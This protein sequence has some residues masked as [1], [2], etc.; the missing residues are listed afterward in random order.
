M[1]R[2]SLQIRSQSVRRFPKTARLLVFLFALF[3]SF[4]DTLS[5]APT[6]LGD[7]DGDGLVN[8]Y[9]LTRLRAHIRGTKTLSANLLP[10]ADVNGDGFLNEDDAVALIHVIVGANPAKTLPL[11][12]IR[13]TSPF[14]G[15]SGVALTR[16]VIVRFTMPLS[17]N[18]TLTTWD[19]NTQTPGDLQAEAG[20]RKLLTRVELSGDR[21]KATL[22][23]LEPVP[24]STRVTVTFDGVGI[25]DLL[26]RQIDP[27]ANN[28]ATGGILTFTYDTAPI[29]AV[30]GTGIIGRVFASEKAA[31]GA[32][33]PLAGALVRVVGSETLQTFTAADG[34]FA[35]TP[36]P[37]GRF[38]VEVDGRT[39]PVSHFPDGAYYPYI[40]KAW[41]TQPGKLD[42]LAVGTGTI[43]LPLVPANTLKPVS[44][45]TPTTIG[46]APSVIAAN[47]ALA[48]VEI[49][50]PANS[51]FA[52]DGTRGG[53]VGLAPV[54]SDRLPEPL[55]P[56]LN[57]VLDI[58][59][60]T[61][62]ATNFDR[63]VPV[64]F[65]NLPDPVTGVKLKP[66]EKSALWSYNHDKGAWEIAGPMTVTDDGN[67]I[68]TDVGVGVRQPGWHGAQPGAAADGGGA[69]QN[70]GGAADP[71]ATERKLLISAWSQ[72]GLSAGLSI[73]KVVPIIGC[74]ISIGQGIVGTIADVTID[75]GGWQKTLLSQFTGTV[76]GCVPF[77]GSPISLAYDCA[78]STG[79]AHD[80]YDACLQAHV[81]G[82]HLRR[83]N[84]ARRNIY[85]E[86]LELSE[87]SS[88]LFVAILGNDRIAAIQSAD[89]LQRLYALLESL[90]KSTA[91]SSPAQSRISIEE[92]IAIK[93]IAR[94]SH[95][96]E[97]EVDALVDRLDKLAAGTLPQSAINVAAISRAAADVVASAR[98]LEA[99]GW[100]TSFD[101]F[102]FGA[103]DAIMQQNKVSNANSR[104]EK[105][106]FYKLQD[107]D[108]GLVRRGTL[109]N[110]SRLPQIALAPNS[111]YV[112]HYLG[113]SSLE[114]AITGFRT[115]GNGSLIRIPGSI[116]S[117]DTQ[118]DADGDGL[119][120]DAE[121][122]IGTDPNRADT[123]GDG[124]SDRTEVQQG[125][126][127]LTGLAVRTG[128]TATVDTPG[129]AT[130]IATLNNVV[131]IA[132]AS[133]GVSVFNAGSSLNP[134]R[135]AQIPLPGSTGAVAIDGARVV[136]A[137]S[138]LALLDLTDLSNVRVT[139]QFD[140]GSTPNAV[141]AVG[142]VAYAGMSNGQ[143]VAIDMATGVEV[144]RIQVSGE[145][146]YDLS[147]AGVVLYV[148]SASRVYAVEIAAG[149]S[150]A[151]NAPVN[152]SSGGGR[153]RLFAGGGLAY[154]PYASGYTILSLADPLHPA[155]M[156]TISTQQLGWRQM[157][158]TGSGLG[159][160]IE[161]VFFG[162]KANLD[163][164]NLGANGTGSQFLTSFITPGQAEA[165]SIYNG[166]A[167][168]A[169]GDAG[170][171]VVNYKAYDTLGVPPTISIGTSFFSV[172][173]GGLQAEE[174][175][176]ARVTALVTDDVQVRNVEFYVDGRLV[177]TDGNFP[178][179]HRF[180]T[181]LITPTKT[182]FTVRARAFDTGGNST[183]SQ[184]L[185]VGL[186]KDATPPRVSKFIPPP[187]SFTG[188]IR[189]VG[190][191]FNEP[192]DPATL[193]VA[194]FA[195]IGAGP[196]GSLG[197]AD[198]VTPTG[199]ALS[200]RDTTNT[201]FLTFPQDL[202][203][204]LYRLTVSA[205]LADLAGNVIAA[206]VE[207]QFRVFGFLDSDGDGVPDDL[208]APLG[209]D[210]HNPD[211]NGN[212][213][214]DGN[215]DFDRDGLPNAFEIAYG[216][217]P[218]RADSNG[219][220]TPD[221]DEDP[222]FDGLT[223]AQEAANGTNPFSSDSDGDGFDDATE[224][225]SGTS[226]ISR[227]GVLIVIE[228]E[229]VSYL[230]GLTEIRL[231]GST[232][233]LVSPS[234]SYLNGLT[235]IALPGALV[236]INSAPVSYLNAL[237]DLSLPGAQL[238]ISSAPVSY[239]NAQ[240]AGFDTGT[241][242]QISTGIV[243]YRK[244]P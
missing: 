24:A 160:G 146:I 1:N 98:R 34:S 48:G 148:R 27:A 228:S 101:A 153:L 205:P 7:L 120:D 63:P 204:N 194:T 187:G 53:K 69:T 196:D 43:Y 26:E 87:A 235:E 94:P 135:V 210:P 72:C 46:F 199:G 30:P 171:T 181:P 4:V 13:E 239:L 207:T 223:N 231:P 93:Q 180:I 203:P 178:F 20:G 33:T 17:V 241:V 225:A 151:G 100:V 164:Y 220:G 115:A 132:D 10:F 82:G 219:N 21:T 158:P 152:S 240:N 49:Y 182:T 23:F 165:V 197:T 140:L 76:I 67:F 99:L 130:D 155:V 169:D 19:A 37:A 62:G 40:V 16:E 229:P 117:V 213:V 163:L 198:D 200:Y 234:V 224:I 42:N 2:A 159:V 112:I 51:L 186:V 170:L 122:I 57:H 45:T 6:I 156:Q 218:G 217:D 125:T 111:R 138:G 105:N 144:E 29:T 60:Q 102:V 136:A 123:D 242:L 84:I 77:F 41:E 114:T 124:V 109:G 176:L 71:C 211:T 113:A 179:E 75:P 128:V 58:S 119:S 157:L 202:P 167:Y 70:P 215:E 201:A 139:H 161:G 32:D 233:T 216:F 129:H 226:P 78:F 142:G 12:S 103:D 5:A 175:K 149:M 131:L 83:N 104:L 15:E 172:V 50:V 106:L 168:V 173:G 230:N 189:T 222:D 79:L 85:Y 38:F 95:L 31:N 66:G 162:A 96:S 143:L 208:E 206:A 145:A 190:A 56:G 54:A 52:D 191:T 236:T 127:P 65:P 97:S 137:G 141:A 214:R 116:L 147:L 107:L 108:S 221:K 35:L 68:V 121:G 91:D 183:W 209:L 11:A 232:I 25:N 177:I 44:A 86:Q 195:L 126:D 90:Q 28:L 64:K 73:P 243:S 193:T 55:P 212:G 188:S 133:A 92:R 184:E 110:D 227:S 36:C 81:F 9:D 150:V 80:D 74:V 14:A 89:D 134:V 238:T 154:A 3:V 59:I 22:F 185:T 166:L 47:P 39:C 8:V 244:N 88:R 237:N 61:D 174:G 192:I 118:V 18:A